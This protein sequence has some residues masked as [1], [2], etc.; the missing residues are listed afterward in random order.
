[1]TRSM[2]CQGI[3][4]IVPLPSQ[5]FFLPFPDRDMAHRQLPLLQGQGK[6]VSLGLAWDLWLVCSR[7]ERKG[8]A[9]GQKGIG[10]RKVL[11]SGIKCEGLRKKDTGTTECGVWHWKEKDIGTRGEWCWH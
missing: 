5:G 3:H 8:L 9:L 2:G 1:M 10:C 6:E 11:A 4:T 7:R